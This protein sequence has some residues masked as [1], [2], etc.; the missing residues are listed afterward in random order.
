[1]HEVRKVPKADFSL[2][3]KLVLQNGHVNRKLLLMG[4]QFNKKNNLSEISEHDF[5]HIK[6]S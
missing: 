4:L 2:M 5:P 3:F 6:K 1:M